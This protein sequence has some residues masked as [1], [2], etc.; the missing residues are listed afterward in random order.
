MRLG[1]SVFLY[2][3]GLCCFQFEKHGSNLEKTKLKLLEAANLVDKVKSDGKY[4]NHK[5]SVFQTTIYLAVTSNFLR[6]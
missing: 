4:E 3:C 5:Q 6:L 2:K 1:V